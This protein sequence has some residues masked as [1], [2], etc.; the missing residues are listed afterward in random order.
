MKKIILIISTLALIAFA[1]WYIASLDSAL[2]NNGDDT[3]GDKSDLI[4]VDTPQAND[5][6]I[7]P[8]T[9]GG[10]ARGYWYFEADFPVRIVDA[11][12]NT[13]GIHY[14]SALGDW[15]TEDFV[16]FESELSFSTPSTDTGTLILERSNPSG[17]AE[18]TDELR[19]PIRFDTSI[20]ERMVKLYYYNQELDTDETGNILCSRDGLVAVER[21]IPT[22]QTPIQDAIKL[23][24]EGNLTAE[25]QEEGISTEYPLEG[26]ALKGANL[27]DGTLSLEFDDPNG[28]TVGGS[29]RTGILWAQIDETAK[30]FEEVQNVEFIPEDLFQP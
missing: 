11:H 6:I 7:S 14:A 17:L 10:E 28:T 26:F 30:Q 19:I 15:M 12:G 21:M 22:T 13:L 3:N 23:L 9:I 1:I 5:L 16:P 29:C 25:E 8:L 2:P 4:R 18:H 24:L 27:V 20:T